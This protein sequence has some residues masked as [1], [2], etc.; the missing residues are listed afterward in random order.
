MAHTK[1]RASPQSKAIN[2]EETET[3]PFTLQDLEKKLAEST[4]H[5]NPD[6]SI[7]VDPT[8]FLSIKL[9]A[10]PKESQESANKEKD[11]ASETEL[12]SAFPDYDSADLSTT[13]YFAAG[14]AAR[15]SA[16]SDIDLE[17]IE[18]IKGSEGEVHSLLD[19][20]EYAHVFDDNYF[21]EIVDAEEDFEPFDLVQAFDNFGLNQE[22]DTFERAAAQASS[23]LQD[24]TVSAFPRT[25][26]TLYCLPC[27]ENTDDIEAIPDDLF[28]IDIDPTALEDLRIDDAEFEF[29]QHNLSEQE[30]HD[31]LQHVMQGEEGFDEGGAQSGHSHGEHARESEQEEAQQIQYIVSSRPESL[32]QAEPLV[33]AF[34]GDNERQCFGH[35]NTIFGL[36]MSA[37]GRYCATASQDSTICVW[38]VKKNALLSTLNGS[39]DHESLRVAWASDKWGVTKNTGGGFERSSDDLILATAGAEGVATMWQ[40]KDG[41]RKWKKVGSV[42]M[43][44]KKQEPIADEPLPSVA[45]DGDAET[46]GEENEEKKAETGGTEIYSLQFI[47]EWNG[48][49]SFISADDASGSL[50]VLMTSSEDFIHIW[51]HCPVSESDESNNDKDQGQLNMEKVMDIKFTHMEHGYG[52]VFVHLNDGSK[53]YPEWTKAQASNIVSNERAFGGDRNPDNLVYVF[54]ALQ[55]PSNNLIGVALSDGTMRLVNGRGVCVTI[56]QLP[57]CQSHLT[58]FSWDRSGRRLASCIATGHV[59]L[60]DIE[61]GDGKGAVQPVCRAVLE[62]GHN[63]GRPLFGAAFFGGDD[64]VRA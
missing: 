35:K 57:G 62:G 28:K 37:C 36:S 1:E 2:Q 63:V 42:D 26:Q 10:T 18:S 4:L 49:P 21:Q 60:W 5:S 51:Q 56:L 13:E 12:L 16:T 40:S 14:T 44:D 61:Y 19:P 23:T 58:S 45:E 27:R 48:L 54:D 31:L 52:G 29:D 24:N 50:G 34:Y 30:L 43:V 59:V 64:E 33:N 46:S 53:D 3:T 55:C 32:K 6:D 11:E 38:D 39:I 9:L 41:G 8:E 22:E 15:T 47:D 7:T 25:G 20:K 17:P